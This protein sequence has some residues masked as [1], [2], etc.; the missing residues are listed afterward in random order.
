[1]TQIEVA[2]AM[3]ITQPTVSRLDKQKNPRL[4]S[5]KRF[6]SA[7]GGTTGAYVGFLDGRVVTLDIKALQ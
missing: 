5:V 2:S 4:S 7:L 6:V 3:N 1:M